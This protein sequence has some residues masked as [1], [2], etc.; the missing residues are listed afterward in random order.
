MNTEPML[1]LCVDYLF[2]RDLLA[3]FVL[4]SRLSLPLFPHEARGGLG[5]RSFY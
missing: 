5:R 4:V 3:G 2:A 1:M